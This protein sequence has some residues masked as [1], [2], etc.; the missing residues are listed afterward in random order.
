MLVLEMNFSPRKIPGLPSGIQASEFR[1]IDAG[2]LFHD[3]P[4]GS[5]PGAAF[6]DFL[7]F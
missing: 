4:L 2:A 1:F 5:S 6:D 7:V 3:S